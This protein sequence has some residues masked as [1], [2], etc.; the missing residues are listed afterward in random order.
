M[1]FSNTMAWLAE[2]YWVVIGVLSGIIISLYVLVSVLVCVGARKRGVDVAIGAM[3]P[4]WH[5]KY[6]F[7][8]K[9]H[10]PK[11]VVKHTKL[12]KNLE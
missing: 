8:G 11:K 12:A 5:I 4:L 9:S 2:N 1:G 10:K 3:I 6:A 7:A